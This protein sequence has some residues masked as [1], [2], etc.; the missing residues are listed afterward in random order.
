L[1]RPTVVYC[2]QPVA[3]LLKTAIQ[4][5][6]VGATVQLFHRQVSL[7]AKI[8]R[9]SHRFFKVPVESTQVGQRNAQ[10][11]MTRLSY[12]PRHKAFASNR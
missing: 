8:E 3:S 6:C 12:A 1:L 7:M 11:P 9:R 4:R 5:D 2:R 10:C